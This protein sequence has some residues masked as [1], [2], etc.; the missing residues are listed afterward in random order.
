[1]SVYRSMAPDFLKD[2]IQVKNYISVLNKQVQNVFNSLDPDDNFT[3]AELNKYK[4]TEDKIALLELNVHKFGSSFKDKKNELESEINIQKNKINMCVRKGNLVSQLNLE[5]DAIRINGNRIEIKTGNLIVTNNEMYAKGNIMARSGHIAGWAID[6]NKWL[7]DSDST[8]NVEYIHAESGS[9]KEVK[10][11][12]DVNIKATLMGNFDGIYCTGSVFDGGISASCLNASNN[13]IYCK[14]LR[15]YESYM[16][17]GETIPKH[18]E[19]PDP[20]DIETEYTNRYNINYDPWG[21]LVVEGDVEC[22]KYYS[23]LA[24][25]T[26]SDRRLKRDI[27][28]VDLKYALDV[29][30]ELRPASFNFKDDKKIRRNGYIAQEVPDEYTGYMRNNALGVRYTS[31]ACTVDKVLIGMTK[32]LNKAIEVRYG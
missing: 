2:E 13:D 31:V 6:N 19:H 10:A 15:C 17:P 21:G 27:K 7:G 8:I 24:K 14:S 5:P 20:D 18:P 4:E 22:K 25:I 26:W 30:R 11:Y 3:E 1:M 16:E 9:A 32:A 29:L 28:A 23:K 12:G